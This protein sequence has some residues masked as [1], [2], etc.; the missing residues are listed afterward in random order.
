MEEAKRFQY[1]RTF[2][3]SLNFE[4]KNKVDDFGFSFQIDPQFDS[5]DPGFMRIITS[6]SLYDEK[7]T[8]KFFE[9]KQTSYFILNEAMEVFDINNNM[10]LRMVE[11]CF[12]EITTQTR[13]ILRDTENFREATIDLSFRE[14]YNNAE[15]T[16]TEK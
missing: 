7:T 11:I 8:D 12:E 15:A 1:D 3:T 6:F 13:T 10:E 5:E 9:L 16:M 2:I 4:E 14:L